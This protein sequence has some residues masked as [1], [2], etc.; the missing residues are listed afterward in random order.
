MDQVGSVCCTVPLWVLSTNRCLGDVQRVQLLHT[1]PADRYGGVGKA[2]GP[3][4]GPPG[5]AGGGG[6]LLAGQG[7][8]A[9]GA[10]AHRVHHTHLTVGDFIGELVI[11]STHTRNR[12][13]YHVPQ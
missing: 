11:L 2:D 3:P 4:L 12:N 6:P 8:A 5:A 9:A 13:V 7:S 1:S 10:E